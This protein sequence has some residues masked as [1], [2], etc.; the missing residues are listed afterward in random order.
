MESQKPAQ[1]SCGTK[2]RALNPGPALMPCEIVKNGSLDGDEGRRQIIETESGLEDREHQQLNANSDNP[3]DIELQPHAK[4]GCH[5]MRSSRYSLIVLRIEE[6]TA[7]D[8][9][10]TIVTTPPTSHNRYSIPAIVTTGFLSK[11]SVPKASTMRSSVGPQ[12]PKE[13]RNT[14]TVYVA[15]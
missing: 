3:D 12:I 5:L 2:P 15:R 13:R 10:A 9:S 1:N 6:Y 14:P 7:K 8:V 11:T 4:R